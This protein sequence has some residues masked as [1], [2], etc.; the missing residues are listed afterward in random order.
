MDRQGENICSMI[1]IDW[2]VRLLMSFWSP[3]PNSELAPLF[4]FLHSDTVSS[5]S[6]SLSKPAPFPVTPHL[7]VDHLP[8]SEIILFIYLVSVYTN[9]YPLE[10][11]HYQGWR[12][13]CFAPYCVPLEQRSAPLPTAYAFVKWGNDFVWFLGKCLLNELVHNYFSGGSHS[14]L[15]F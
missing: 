4:S 6:A 3:S 9:L 1:E 8:C 2:K 5:G 14:L 12:H 10:C 13:L 11:K 15:K 7:S